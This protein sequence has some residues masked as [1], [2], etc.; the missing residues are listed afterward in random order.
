MIILPLAK[1]FSIMIVR[2]VKMG[3]DSSQVASFKKFFSDNEKRI[4][5]FDG[6]LHL[7]LLQDKKKSN[8]F[9]TYSHW[10]TE[11]HLE[12]YRNS[13]FF[14]EVWSNTKS[15]FNQRPEAWSMASVSY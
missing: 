2:I 10:K 9:F 7:E 1:N 14:K 11:E 6:C 15:K 13:D 3:F 12:K 4:R 8:Q 5:T